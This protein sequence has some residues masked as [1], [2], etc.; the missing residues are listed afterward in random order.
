MRADGIATTPMLRAA[1][2][3]DAATL[4]DLAHSEMVFIAGTGESL[5]VYQFTRDKPSSLL[6]IPS[7]AP[8]LPPLKGRDTRIGADARGVTVVASA[9]I[10]G[11]RAGVAGGVVISTP[12]DLTSIQR[13][14]AEHSA[15]ASLTGMGSELVL[16]DGHGDAGG[17]AVK[18]AVPSSGD[19]NAGAA[20]LVATPRRSAGLTWAWPARTMSGGLSAL[21]LLGFVV[22]LV[23]RSRS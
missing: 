21:L 1:I 9:P 23:R 13:A 3:T 14:L 7:A 19:W 17:A 2:E 6:R 20:A 10:S 16:F 18:L 15:G 22:G 11:Y 8:A 4:R 12:V 5:E